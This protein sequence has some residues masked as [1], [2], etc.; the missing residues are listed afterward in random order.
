[1]SEAVPATP[2]FPQYVWGPA[3]P[4]VNAEWELIDQEVSPVTPHVVVEESN[5]NSVPNQNK[6]RRCSDTVSGVED[7]SFTVDSDAQFRSRFQEI[8]SLSDPY[9]EFNCSPDTTDVHLLS[10]ALVRAASNPQPLHTATEIA[11][12]RLHRQAAFMAFK[13]L[14]LE[15]Q[16]EECFRALLRLAGR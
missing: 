3:S 5:L 2:L 1:M 16:S 4:S 11:S 13:S 8:L 10:L 9:P 6:R 15:E 7:P 12:N 14:S